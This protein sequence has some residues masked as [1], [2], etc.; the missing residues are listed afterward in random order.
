MI[1]RRAVAQEVQDQLVAAV[2]R[3][4]EQL[5]KSREQMRKSHDELHKR[6]EA[7]VETMRASSKNGKGT[8]LTIPSLPENLRVPSLSTLPSPA[9]LRANAHE[10]AGHVIATQRAPIFTHSSSARP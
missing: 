9:K 7:L 4:Q 8:R 10:L 1:D 2:H 3:G 6:R 5:R